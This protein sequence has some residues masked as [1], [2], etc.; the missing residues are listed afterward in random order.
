M[1]YIILEFRILDLLELKIKCVDLIVIFIGNSGV[2][3]NN[4]K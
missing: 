2:C 3:I 4:N 1:G